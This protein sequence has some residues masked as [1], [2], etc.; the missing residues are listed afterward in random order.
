MSEQ[1]SFED[2][3]RSANDPDVVVINNDVYETKPA[4]W[5]DWLIGGILVGTFLYLLRQ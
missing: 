1:I 4:S 5:T 3:E 2:Y